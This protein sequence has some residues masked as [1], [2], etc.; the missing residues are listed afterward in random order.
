MGDKES[1]RFGLRSQADMADSGK[2]AVALRGESS[3][4]PYY[5]GHGI[6]KVYYEEL[7][8]IVEVLELILPTK[9]KSEHSCRVNCR[10]GSKR[11]PLKHRRGDAKE[12]G[13]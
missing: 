9:E 2:S 4:V 1:F 6:M 3:A 7:A 13:G 5:M 8:E 12:C 10:K 11:C